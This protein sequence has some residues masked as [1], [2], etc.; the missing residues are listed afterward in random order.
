MEHYPRLKSGNKKMNPAVKAVRRVSPKPAPLKRRVALATGASSGI[1]RAISMALADAGASVFLVGRNV[2]NLEATARDA[3]QKTD[4]VWICP[5]D[6]CI[7]S[8]IFKLSETVAREAGQLDILILCAGVYGGGKISETCHDVM[9][10]LYRANV[11]APLLLVQSFLPLLRKGKGQIV[12][13][14]SSAGL[15]AR[16]NAGP[17]SA[18][19][20]ALR[21]MA[22]AMRVDLNQDG[23]R[24]L[25]VFPG[26]T[27]TPRMKALYARDGK[28]Y[29]PGVLMQP[30]DIARMVVQAISLPE[31]AEVTEIHMRPM[32]K[33]Y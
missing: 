14:N 3:Q 17:H 24:V 1:G 22:D 32:R 6:L 29:E 28:T 9:D 25:N 13:V 8:E 12:F 10:E 27:A 18:M 20:H 2:E 5:T 26:R 19:Q 33:S 23:I 21:A 11:R 4:N 16:A 7:E 31:T 15:H 30:E